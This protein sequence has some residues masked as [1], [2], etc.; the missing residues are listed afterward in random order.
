MQSIGKQLLLAT[1]LMT[2]T[3]AAMLIQ[4]PPGHQG[5]HGPAT[6]GDSSHRIPP[7]HRGGRGPAGSGGPAVEEE[8]AEEE[9]EEIVTELTITEGTQETIDATHLETIIVS[10]TNWEFEQFTPITNLQPDT[11]ISFQVQS[12]FDESVVN[13][14]EFYPEDIVRDGVEIYTDAS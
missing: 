11:L 1:A 12:M 7:G 8:A 5:G 10:G 13:I 9:E 2:L 3:E 6:T 4:N 14:N